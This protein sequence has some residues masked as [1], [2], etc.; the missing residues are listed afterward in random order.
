MT[1][2]PSQT[3][4]HPGNTLQA[5]ADRGDL[6]ACFQMG[7]NSLIGE[8]VIQSDAAAVDYWK[9]VHE[10]SADPVEQPIATLMLGWLH[11]LGRGTQQDKTKGVELVRR[12]KTELIPLGEDE[13]FMGRSMPAS[14]SA[15]A[16]RFFELCRLGSEREWLCKHL[17]AI[18]HVSGFGTTK[19]QEAYVDLFEELAA[20][21]HS[22]SQVW[23]GKYYSQDWRSLGDTSRAFQLWSNAAD[24][25]NSYGQYLLGWCYLGG[26]GVA[27]NYQKAVEWYRKSAEQGNQHGQSWLGDCYEEGR[28]GIAKDIEAALY[29]F[30]LAASQGNEYAQDKLEELTQ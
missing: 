20:S 4:D 27:R 22:D 23:L 3:L 5:A 6:N 29:W 25:D 24:Q 1:D 28:K 15:A 8:G 17:V 30:R 21:G 16:R 26:H 19:D 9:Q 14:D 18:C 10:G 13:C 2:A 12:S 11:Y 7:W